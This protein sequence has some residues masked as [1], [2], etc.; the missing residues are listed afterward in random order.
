M[1]KF[2][3][4]ASVAIATLM[5]ASCQSCTKKVD[6]V[7]VPKDTTIVV[8][9]VNQ[10]DFNNMSLQFGPTDFKWYETNILLKEFLDE[11]CSGE[12]QELVNIYQTITTKDSLSYDT[13]VFK[14]QH[15]TDGSE[16]TDSIKGFWIEDYPIN[17]DDIKISYKEAFDK[18]MAAN[19][20][21]PHSRYVTIR[22]PIGPLACNPQYVF[23]NI[24]T[25]VWVDATTGEVKN[26]NP[27]FPKDFT[28]SAPLG[29]WP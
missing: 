23:G 17:P 25:Q 13:Q 1:K 11:E 9:T 16:I 29:E 15:F 5:M 7:V 4:F 26:N 10:T 27:A 19:I 28:F 12:I 24:K 8:E 18:V 20:I 6:P 14:I 21:K 3:L 22:K 2:I